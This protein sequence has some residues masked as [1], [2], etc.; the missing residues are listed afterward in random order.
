MIVPMKKITLVVLDREREAALAALRKTGVM[1]VKKAEAAS[2]SLTDLTSLASRMDQAYGILSEIPVEKKKEKTRHLSREDTLTLVDR[3]LTL[4]DEQ[5]AAQETIFRIEKEFERL[6]AW[7]NV[8]PDAFDYLAGKGIYLF[9]FEMSV[10]DYVNLPESVRTIVVGR[11]KKMIRCVIWGE[12]DLLHVDMPRS[13]QELVLP[14]KST[15]ALR[16]ELARTEKLIPD[17]SARIAADAVHA[18][19]ILRIKA[20]IEKEIEFETVRAGMSVVSLAEEGCSEIGQ[21]SSLAWLTGYVPVSEEHLISE[22]AKKQGWALVSDDPAEDDEVPTQIKNNRFVNLISPLLDFLGTVPGYYEQDISLWFLIFFGIFFAMIFGDA[23]YGSLI[24]LMSLGGIIADMRK[25]KK[26]GTGFFMFL[27]L[28]LMTVA[29]GMITCNWF[30]I[31]PEKMPTAFRAMAIPAFS[32]ENPESASNIQVFCFTLGLLQLSLAHIIGVFRNI[33]S[34]RALG[35]VG[36]LCMTIGMYSVVLN[37]IVDTEKYPLSPVMLGLIAVG[38]VLNF[39]FINYAGKIGKG[40]LESLKNIITMLLGVVNVFGDIMSYIRLWAVGLAGAAISSTVNTMAG[41]ILGGFIIFLGIVLLLFGHGLNII[42][43]ALSVIV[44]GVRLNT[45][46]FSNHL[47]LTWS[48][49]KY[50][51][52]SETVRK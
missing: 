41:P 4:R 1:H 51:P 16:E 31:S 11:D 35:D 48:G 20:I 10:N 40:I 24:V 38:F 46:E 17:I 7:G 36:S 49:F 30:G 8:D 34:L 52:F 26:P 37:L 27:Y 21:N 13:A 42:L 18:D 2:Q 43:N 29:W 6:R 12:D 50:E 3:V 28:G 9:P 44:H 25:Q 15:S 45:L 22:A 14:A 32:G 47:G 23:G 33:K 5:R 19:S 39:V